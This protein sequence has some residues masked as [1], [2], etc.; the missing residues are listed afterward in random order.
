MCVKILVDFLG[1]I[2]NLKTVKNGRKKA[3]QVI[4]DLGYFLTC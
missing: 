3:P 4:M 1:I 2:S